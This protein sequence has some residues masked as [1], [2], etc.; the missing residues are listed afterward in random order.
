MNRVLLA[1]SVALV[2]GGCPPR[3]PP[4]ELPPSPPYT[5]VVRAEPR[6]GSW[7]AGSFVRETEG[8]TQAWTCDCNALIVS[9]GCHLVPELD[10]TTS[11]AC[12]A[13]TGPLNGCTR[14]LALEPAEA[15]TCST[16][17]P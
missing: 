13:D 16:A 4:P 10:T 6:A 5:P 14:C 9:A 1:A 7:R 15:C 12:A 8:C 11:G 2:M 17:C 3:P